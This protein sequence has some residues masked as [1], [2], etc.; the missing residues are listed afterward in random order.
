MAEKAEP[1]QVHFTLCLRNQQ[2]MRMQDGCK[3]YM[4]SY[5][6]SNGSY[7]MVTWIVLKNHRLKVGMTQKPEDHGTLNV[8]KH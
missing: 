7:F 4:G 1:V 2:S 3:F 6:A 5:M 8:H